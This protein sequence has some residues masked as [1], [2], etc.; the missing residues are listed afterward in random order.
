MMLGDVRADHDQ[1][2]RCL[3]RNSIKASRWYHLIALLYVVDWQ[4]MAVLPRMSVGENASLRT[5]SHK[6]L[7]LAS[8]PWPPNP[9]RP[10]LFSDSVPTAVPAAR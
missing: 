7:T 8:E 1:I 4:N 10:G 5:L 9:T 6:W 3:L 2:V